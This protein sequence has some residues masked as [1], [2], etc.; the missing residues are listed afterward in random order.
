MSK[1]Y[2]NR[3]KAAPAVQR[4][5]TAPA[6]PSLDA[7]RSGASSPSA[8][9]MGHRVDLPDAMR[10]KM[11]TAFGADLSSVRLYQSEAVR[12]AG[13][14]AV[15]Q[16][17]NIAFA[18]GML[19]FSSYGGQA[20]LGHEISHVVS[21]ARGEVTGTGLLNDPALEARADRE[22]AMAAAGQQVSTP[23]EAM[24]PVT[25]APAAGP[26]QCFGKKK[27]EPLAEGPARRGFS[28]R[29]RKEL[30]PPS[31]FTDASSVIQVNAEGEGPVV[32][33]AGTD[34]KLEKTLSIF[35][36]MAG[37]SFADMNRSEG[38]SAWSLDA[39]DV[40]ALTPEEME[41]MRKKKIIGNKAGQFH[42]L[43]TGHDTTEDEELQGTSVFSWVNGKS[44]VL[45]DDPKANDPG[46]YVNNPSD[47]KD[48]QN[49]RIALGYV[50]LM[51]LATGNFDRMARQLNVGNWTEERDKKR[52]HL[53]DNDYFDQGGL[54]AD[55][56]RGGDRSAWLGEVKKHLGHGAN[57]DDLGIRFMRQ[58]RRSADEGSM[59]PEETNRI[60]AGGKAAALGVNQGI[61][62]LPQMRKQLKAQFKQNSANGDLDDYQKEL[63]E[64][65]KIIY[66]YSTDPQ[67]AELYE[68]L[69]DPAVG[70]S[71]KPNESPNDTNHREQ[72]LAE[73]QRHRAAAKEQRRG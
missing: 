73:I 53:I 10:E 13:V 30:K 42:S 51:D 19:D 54:H 8:E 29:K 52:I 67:M 6:E 21:Q 49:Y 57:E 20:L 35:Y 15:T 2:E 26:M 55:V 41:T 72:L 68:A 44:R 17:S 36:N 25:A 50:S 4:H 63:L 40:R 58:V 62:A 66:E 56:V 47:P 1:I 24:S 71:K 27:K 37:K 16:G 65:M 61:L 11:E 34:P 45:P 70:Y 12:D 39:P 18:P 48:L 59:Y 64:R 23:A 9:Q 31:G 22:G 60:L 69:G 38:E 43:T 14:K 46:S 7:L 33:K 5:E 28:L 32:L 3:K